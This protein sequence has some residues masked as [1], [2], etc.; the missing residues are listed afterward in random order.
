ML[1]AKIS[2]CHT[3]LSTSNTLNKQQQ[4]TARATKLRSNL[5]PAENC[6]TAHDKNDTTGVLNTT[7]ATSPY[8]LNETE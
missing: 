2:R 5:R 4:P 3:P 8:I 7:R 6:A 1:V